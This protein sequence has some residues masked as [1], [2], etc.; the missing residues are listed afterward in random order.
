MV[1][2]WPIIAE[3]LEASSIH[4]L[5]YLSECRNLI[6]KIIWSLLIGFSF[7]FAFNLIY[8]F[9]IQSH[10]EPLL[11]TLETIPTQDVPFPAITI[12]YIFT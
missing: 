12:R 3:Y 8:T 2:I 5:R 4:G 7:C 6:V 11:T 9:L 1:N 10:E